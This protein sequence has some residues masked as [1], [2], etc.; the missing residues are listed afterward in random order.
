MPIYNRGGVARLRTGMA[1][2]IAHVHILPR[3]NVNLAQI[4]IDGAIWL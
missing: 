3:V 1:A 4:R 2:R